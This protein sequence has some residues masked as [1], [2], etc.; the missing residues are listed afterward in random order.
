MTDTQYTTNALDHF[1]TGILA[2]AEQEHRRYMREAGDD[3]ELVS[4]HQRAMNANAKALRH[5][6]E[7]VR[8]LPIRAGQY[9]LP[10]AT[11]LGQVYIVSGDDCGCA[12]HRNQALPFCWHQALVIAYEQAMDVADD[13]IPLP[14]P[15][16]DI[17]EW[18]G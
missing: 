13:D 11:S 17:E 8:P 4:L 1:V 12:Q 16:F 15:Q 9:T 7:G 2:D 10:S 6:Q 5:W 14:E 3:R 18:F